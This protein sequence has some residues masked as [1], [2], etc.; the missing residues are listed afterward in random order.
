MPSLI[1]PGLFDAPTPERAAWID[2]RLPRGDYV[3]VS[4]V[5]SAFDVCCNT[6]CAWIEAGEFHRAAG[7]SE[8]AVMNLGAASAP[9]YR[10]ARP[11]V[12]RFFMIRAGLTP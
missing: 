6:V 1:Q 10:I 3:S 2:G 9:R 11:S 4:D 8:P 5:A 12:I 7:L